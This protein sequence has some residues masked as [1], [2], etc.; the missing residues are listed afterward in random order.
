M[1]EKR[2]PLQQMVLGRVAICMLKTELDPCLSPCTSIN[3]KW[4]KDLNTRPETLQL[5]HER[6]GKTL[7]AIGIARTSSVELQQ[8]SN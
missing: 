1:M 3:S 2:H 6:A 8:P 4:I 7:E 5:V